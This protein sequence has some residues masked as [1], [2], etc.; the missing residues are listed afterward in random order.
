M[1]L[2][3]NNNRY[4]YHNIKNSNNNGEIE[5]FIEILDLC[6]TIK[7]MKIKKQDGIMTKER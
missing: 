3:D 2:N 7:K 5:L 4:G 6:L 1:I